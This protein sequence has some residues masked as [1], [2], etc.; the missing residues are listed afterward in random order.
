[1]SQP[2]PSNTIDRL[3]RSLSRAARRYVRGHMITNTTALMPLA[4]PAA[5]DA[6]EMLRCGKMRDRAEAIQYLQRRL[7]RVDFTLGKDEGNRRKD[8]VDQLAWTDARNDINRC[9]EA[10]SAHAVSSDDEPQ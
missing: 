4:E 10:M 6:A 1:M 7:F 9:R 3:D 8:E 5:A 2:L